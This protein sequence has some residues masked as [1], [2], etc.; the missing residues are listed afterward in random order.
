MLI[1]DLVRDIRVIDADAHVPEPPDLWTSRVSSKW[2][3]KV[4]RV[5]WD[6]AR[7]ADVWMADGQF[8]G[9][10]G[11]TATAGHDKPHPEHPRRWADIPPALWRAEDRLVAMTEFGIYAAVLYPNVS[12]FGNSHLSHAAE[13]DPGLGLDLVRAYNDF[14]I[15]YCSADPRRYVPIMGIPFWDVDLSIAEMERAARMGHRGFLLS[16]QPELYGSPSLADRRWDKLWAAAQDM[17]LSVNFHIGSG[18]MDTNLLPP[19]A[20][21][22][23]NAAIHPSMTF[24]GAGRAMATLIGGGVCHR[25]PELKIV[26]VESGLGWIPFQLQALDWMWGETDVVQEHPEYDLLP[27]EYFRR[28]FFACFWFERGESLDAALSFLGDENVLYETDYPHPAGMTPGPASKA[29]AAKDFI[30]QHLGHL[31]ESTLRRI[32]HDNAANLYRID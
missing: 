24:M 31:P 5:V 17:Q 11:S 19:D 22:R 26:I 8:L 20:G 18:A 23:A 3:D 27:S 15:D 16:Q 1:E 13:V 9:A 21:Q 10:C 29:V 25:F 32:L 6:E 7:Q 14:L 28:Q 12:L 2:G 4:P 30:P